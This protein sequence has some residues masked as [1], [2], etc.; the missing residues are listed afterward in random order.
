MPWVQVHL[1]KE[2]GPHDYEAMK[3][4]IAKVLFEELEKPEQGLS[5]SFYAAEAFYR[6][7]ESSETAAALEVKYIGTFALEKKQ[8]VTRRISSFLAEKYG[9]DPMKTVIVFTEIDSAN[10]GRRGGDFS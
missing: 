8:A 1:P 4:E 3:S 5:V 2:Y 10:W 9:Y 7:G 6:A